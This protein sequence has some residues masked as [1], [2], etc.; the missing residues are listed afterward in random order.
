MKR[1][2]FLAL[3][4]ALGAACAPAVAQPTTHSDS[5]TS[6]YGGRVTEEALA[7]LHARYNGV[8]T[9]VRDL[10]RTFEALRMTVFYGGSREEDCYLTNAVEE[11][12][13]V[14]LGPSEVSESAAANYSP[15]EGYLLGDGG[16]ITAFTTA[17]DEYLAFWESYSDIL[18]DVYAQECIEQHGVEGCSAAVGTV[19]KEGQSR[20]LSSL[21]SRTETLALVALEALRRVDVNG[22]CVQADR[23]F[24][25]IYACAVTAV[26]YWPMLVGG[27]LPSPD[28]LPSTLEDFLGL[29]ENVHYDLYDALVDRIFGS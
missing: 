1:M 26:G 23:E 6:W 16:R 24:S 20:F 3:C 27:F 22:S 5:S 21:A 11:I 7:E 9:A 29:L 12:T 13:L 17:F 14:L 28:T 15:W 10:S 8:K 2:A 4:I 18:V 19:M 25:T